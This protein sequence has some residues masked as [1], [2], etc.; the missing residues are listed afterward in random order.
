MANTKSA[1]KRTR[2]SETRHVRN[3]WY[4]TRC[5]TFVKRA[6][7]QMASGDL[8]KAQDSVRRAGQALDVASQKGVIHKN[9]AART[10]SRL[11]LALN[12]LTA[13]GGD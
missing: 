13:G 5:R 11:A 9:A 1:E 10:K 2:Q 7:A 3:R 8:E 12:K 4:R 6:R